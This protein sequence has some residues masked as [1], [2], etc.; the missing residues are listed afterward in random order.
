MK[1]LKDR[2]EKNE[3]KAINKKIKILT[4]TVQ[5]NEQELLEASARLV[6]NTLQDSFYRNNLTDV[7]I[8]SNYI[9]YDILEDT[10]DDVVSDNIVAVAIITTFRQDDVKVVIT[11]WCQIEDKMIFNDSDMNVT[12]CVDLPNIDEDT[13][14]DIGHNV[15]NK[16]QLI[17]DAITSINPQ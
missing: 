1:T 10:I 9:V 4:A 15:D 12:A 2:L 13:D 17:L 8:D 5:E 14:M 16:V 3:R 11:S 7:H 6:M